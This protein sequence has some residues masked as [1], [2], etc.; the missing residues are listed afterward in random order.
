MGEHEIV[1]IRSLY[2][3]IANGKRKCYNEYISNERPI[4]EHTEMEHYRRTERTARTS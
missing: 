4:N 1:D 2:F 3:A